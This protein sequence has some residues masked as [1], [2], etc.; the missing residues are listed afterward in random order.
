MQINSRLGL[1]LTITLVVDYFSVSS[2]VKD[3]YLHKVMCNFFPAGTQSVEVHVMYSTAN[4]WNTVRSQ[5]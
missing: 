4:N 2:L 5:N 1:S 3:Y